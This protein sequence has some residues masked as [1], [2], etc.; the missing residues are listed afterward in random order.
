MSIR[1]IDVNFVKNVYETEAI[2]SIYIDVVTKVGIW[3][4]EK[5]IAKK[6][7]N[8]NDRILDIACGAGRSTFGFYDQGFHAVEGLD[9][10]YTLIN[11]AKNI[12]IDSNRD[13]E[14]HQGNL[15]NLKFADTSFDGAFIS[16]LGL[17]CIPGVENRIAGLKEIYRVLKPNSI[18]IFVTTEDIKKLLPPEDLEREYEDWE[19][20]NRDPRLF[21]VGDRLFYENGLEENFGHFPTNQKVIEC[22]KKSGFTLCESVLR[23]DICEE[24]ERVMNFGINPV[25]YWVVQK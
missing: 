16:Y 19:N 8:I 12:A 21:E 4:S 9:L 6:Y 20:N 13:I 22:I 24:P 3:E 10:S 1:K 11:A 14:F 7:F 18:L 25:R 5:I 2:A 15:L 17:M 23:E